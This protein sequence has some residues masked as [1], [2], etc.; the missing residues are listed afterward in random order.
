M[1]TQVNPILY[2]AS[3]GTPSNFSLDMVC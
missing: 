1:P 2:S 3:T